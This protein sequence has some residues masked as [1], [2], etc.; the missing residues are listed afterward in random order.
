MGPFLCWA[1]ILGDPIS[2]ERGEVSHR[3]NSEVT[4][5]SLH[6]LLWGFSLFAC[7]PQSDECRKSIVGVNLPRKR[8]R[9]EKVK[10]IL[11]KWWS[12]YIWSFWLCLYVLVTIGKPCGSWFLLHSESLKILTASQRQPCIS[13]SQNVHWRGNCLHRRVLG[14]WH[15]AYRVEVFAAMRVPYSEVFESFTL[16]P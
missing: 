11:Y 4:R 9:R 6:H 1:T 3:P 10:H 7:G 8:E 14:L 12:I 5:Q 15:A 2:L 13:L 16:G